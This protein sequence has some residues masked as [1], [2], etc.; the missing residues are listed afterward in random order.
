MSLFDTLLSSSLILDGVLAQDNAQV[1]SLWQIRELCPESLSK[2]GTAY[3]YDLSVP[4]E[5]MY[6]VVERMRAH[7]KERGLLGGKVKYVAGFGHMGDGW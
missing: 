3:K 5:K 1:Y 2:A 7:L 4:V 6:E